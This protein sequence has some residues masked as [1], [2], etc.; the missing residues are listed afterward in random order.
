MV[1]TVRVPHV[2]E[3]L[4]GWRGKRIILGELELCGKDS[5]LERRALGALDETLPVEEV[6]FGDGTRGDA[7]GWVVGERA[8][9]LEETA[10]GGGR[11]DEG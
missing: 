1:L 8:I 6:I 10:V 3:E 9:L 5:A 4:H 2:G 7:L 11:H